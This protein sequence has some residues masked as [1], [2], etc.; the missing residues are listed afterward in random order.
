MSDTHSVTAEFIAEDLKEIQR[1]LPPN[2]PEDEGLAHVL[3]EALSIYRRDEA[4]W[5]TIEHLHD[6]TGSAAQV[7][8]KRREASGLLVSM[9]SRTI[10][11]EMGMYELREQVRT[12][13][14]RHT[15]QRARARVIQQSLTRL[16]RRIQQA[17]DRLSQAGG[18]PSTDGRPASRLQT[19][20]AALWKRHV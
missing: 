7:E 19:R 14:E 2:T 17:E 20:L 16:R 18:V 5:Q 4:A 10:R 6:T 15:L 9:R 3:R 1:L 11:S 13:Q 12:L 8:L